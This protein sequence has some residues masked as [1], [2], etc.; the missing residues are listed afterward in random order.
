MFLVTTC[1]GDQFRCLDGL[2]LSI[3]K[4]CNGISDCRN[5]EDEHQCGKLTRFFLLFKTYTYSID[6]HTVRT[7]IERTYDISMMRISRES[8]SY[9]ISLLSPSIVFADRWQ[10]KLY[11]AACLQLIIINNHFCTR[12]DNSSAMVPAISCR[13]KLAPMLFVK[14]RLPN[15]I[16]YERSRGAF[17]LKRASNAPAKFANKIARHSSI[18]LADKFNSDLIRTRN[19]CAL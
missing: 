15:A 12:D 19:S 4:R 13:D 2:C 6:S 8:P 11:V 14:C 18:S 9:L 7:Q 3:D 1:S 10:H 16:I 5:G 17:E